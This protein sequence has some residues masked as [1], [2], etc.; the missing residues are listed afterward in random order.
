VTIDPDHDCPQQQE[1]QACRTDYSGDQRVIGLPLDQG[2]EGEHQEQAGA[3]HG[4]GRT[5]GDPNRSVEGRLQLRLG[6]SHLV[7]DQLADVVREAVDQLCDG[8][9]RQFR[10][11][12]PRSVADRGSRFRAAYHQVVA[13]PSPRSLD[14]LAAPLARLARSGSLLVATDFDGTLAPVVRNPSRARPLPMA[15]QALAA[16]A[17]RTPVAVISGRDLANLFVQCP[18]PGVLLLGS[19]GLEPWQEA[20]SLPRPLPP[21]NPSPR[22]QRLAS[23]LRVSLRGLDGV[24]VETKTLGVAVHYRNAPDRHTIGLELR[25]ILSLVSHREELELLRG[26][27]VLELR[28]RHAGDK[29]TAL[30]QLLE[31]ISPRGCV[32][33]GDDLGDIPAMVQLHRWSGDLELAL[34][35]GVLSQETPDQV[36]EE[37]DVC[38]EG[39]EEWAKLLATVLEELERAA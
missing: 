1:H 24:E 28:D 20:G 5:H 31:R 25:R 17:L 11:D 22:L 21:S 7:R 13:G 30:V 34:A 12:H 29:G 6:Q 23:E 27:R 15:A 39:P 35:I 32:Y 19:Y 26:R 2:D 18:M 37:A 33:A 16:L 9:L 4:H 8:L 38:L 3:Q 10:A 36:R 14:D